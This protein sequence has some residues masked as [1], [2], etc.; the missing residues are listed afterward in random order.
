MLSGR[1]S[2]AFRTL[3][4]VVLALAAQREVEPVLQQLA[5]AARELGDARYSAL[6]VP[7]GD[8]GFARFITS[9]MS[10]EL[11]AA[12][13]PLPR[14]HGMLG[15]M[16]DTR[17][18]YRTGDIHDHP[19]FRGWWPAAHPDMR[20]FLGVPIVARG[21]VIGALYLTDKLGGGAFTEED[22]RLIVLLAAHAAIA[23]ENARLHERARELSIVEERNRLAR[24]LHDAVTQQLFGVVLAAESAGELLARGDGAAGVEVERVQTLAR[25]A[26]EEL[27]S[28]VFELRPASMEADGL[29]TGAAQAR[30][31][32]AA[33]VGARARA[34]RRHTAAARGR[35]V[36]RGVPDRAGGAAERAAPRGGRE[37]RGPARR[38]RRA[39]RA[40]RGRRRPRVRPRGGGAPRPAA[41]ADL[42][43]GARGRAGRRADGVLR[44]RRRDDRAAR[45]A[46]VI[47]VLIADDHAVVRGGL[48]T[49]LDLQPDL[50]VVAEAADGEAAVREAV[51]SAPDVVLLD[52][53]MPVLDGAAALPRLRER[54]PGARVIV[55]TSFGEDERLFTALRAGA[56]GFLLKDTEPADLV[57]AIRTAHAGQAPLSPAV[58]TRLVDRLADGGRPRAAELL[59]PRELEVLGLIAR[60]YANKRIALE[61]G[62][63]EKTVKTHVGHVLAKLELSDR[64]QA[65]LYAVREGLAPG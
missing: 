47:R 35:R 7:D 53:V 13:G 10:D 48:R 27:R 11:I 22:E 14:T 5:H 19:R 3:S 65:A 44:P 23:I 36:G 50:E 40:Q 8:G 58:A 17:E 45:G 34:R 18:P 2:T 15:A 51:R 56:A 26:M 64:T 38:G 42:D 32:A 41:R 46:G 24:E 33:G 54:V 61:L 31:R 12:M 63:A 21:G 59:T 20:S 30:R 39:A 37:D 29:G 60:G 4:D 25:A 16:L 1:D 9:G 28:V 62:V 43:G 55:L 6:G 57:R 49:Y 52:L